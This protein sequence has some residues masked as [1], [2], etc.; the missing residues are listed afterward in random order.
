VTV[1]SEKA[2]QNDPES[3]F[4]VTLNNVACFHKDELMNVYKVREYLSKAGPVPFGLDFP[5]AQ[6]IERH[7][8][9]VPGYRAYCVY[10]NDKKIVRPHESEVRLTSSR[11]D[12][13]AEIKCFV[14]Y[15]RER[16]KEIGRG[17]YAVT[18]HLASM[19]PSIHMRGVWVRQGNIGVGDEHF[20]AEA[21][22][23]RRFAVWH[24]GEIHLGYDLKANAR[25][26]GFEHGPEHEVFLEQ[27]CL[28]GGHLSKLCRQASEKRSAGQQLERIRERLKTLGKV[29]LVADETQLAKLCEEECDLRARLRKSGMRVPQS[30]GRARPHML[31]DVL[32]G[33][34]LRGLSMKDILVDVG[35]R[36]AS[37]LNDS[38][39]AAH[40]LERVLEPYLK[41][42]TVRADF[43]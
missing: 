34:H 23:E 19:P 38:G 13:I 33:R 42:G 14:L 1:S 15:D 30:N 16:T 18:S 43:G 32:D 3:F 27:V 37:K 12:R 2:S 22:T 26:D 21:F 39:A 24:I 11:I 36:L 41:A 4:R 9:S 6:E 31:P 10:V 5:F 29:S 28:L 40:M 17:W 8:R 20:L 7:L 25:R 35:R